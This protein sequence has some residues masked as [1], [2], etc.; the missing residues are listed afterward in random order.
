MKTLAFKD[1]ADGYYQVELSDDASVPDWAAK[2]TPCEVILP[3][4]PV[5]APPAPLSITPWQIRKAL[6]QLELDEQVE[7]MVAASDDKVLKA[8][9]EYATEFVETDP[10]VVAM[11]ASLGKTPEELHELFL[12][13]G[14]L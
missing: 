14:T 5:I 7:A 11:G 4:E 12:F 3:P 1:N 6:I 2:L 13:A 9:W 10:F 8:G